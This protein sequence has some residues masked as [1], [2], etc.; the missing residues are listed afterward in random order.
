MADNTPQSG[1][2]TIATDDVTTLNGAASSGVKVQRVK[3]AFGDDGAARDASAVFPLPVA[4]G[5]DNTAGTMTNAPNVTAVTT[6]A[7]Q[8]LA[9]GTYRA[10]VLE[11]YG[12][13]NIYVGA[14]GVTA[15]SHFKRLSPGEVLTLTPPFVPSNAIFAIAGSGT[16]SLQIG[17]VT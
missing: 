7:A 11:N 13:D 3:V 10:I 4:W 9:P 14:T 16:Q 5:G 8:V 17:A 6:T 15:S 12:S 1:T 2:D